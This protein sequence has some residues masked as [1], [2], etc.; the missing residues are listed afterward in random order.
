MNAL[1]RLNKARSYLLIKQPFYGIIASMIDFLEIED[2]WC[3][4]IATDGRKFYYNT[5]FLD[6]LD[7]QE[8]IGVTLHELNHCIFMHCDK[9]HVMLHQ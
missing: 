5:K 6:G 4:T 1:D 7:D 3:D 8:L 9:V 2:A